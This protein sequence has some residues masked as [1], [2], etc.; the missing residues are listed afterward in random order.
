VRGRKR[1]TSPLR[2]KPARRVFKRTFSDVSEPHSPPISS[3][4]AA[5]VVAGLNVE[6]RRRTGVFSRETIHAAINVSLSVAPGGTLAIV[7]ESGSGKS[8]VAR[9]IAGLVAAR[10]GTVAITGVRVPING[11]WRSTQLRRLVQMVFQ[12]PAGS[13]NP[14]HRIEEIVSEPLIV[15]RPNLTRDE[16]RVATIEV[17]DRCGLPAATLD[18]YPHQFSGGQKQRIALARAIILK[19]PLVICDEPTSALDVSIQARMINLLRDLQRQL[20]LAYLFISHDLAVVRQMAD[21][22]AVMTAGRIVETGPTARIIDEPAHDYTKRLI[23][24]AH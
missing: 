7:G 3:L 15:H 11:S 23:A 24:A 10:S 14:M 22:T 4:S 12:D 5:L 18:R 9:A 19:P 13:M 16:R 20:G 17:L 1:I 6:F 2:V 8:T 21:H